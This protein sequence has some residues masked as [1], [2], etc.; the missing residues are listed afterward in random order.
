MMG[1]DATVG[2][3]NLYR[4]GQSNTSSVNPKNN[5]KHIANNDVLISNILYM[6]CMSVVRWLWWLWL[7]NVVAVVVV[8][9]E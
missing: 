4:H 1:N 3:I 9:V 2:N 6:F 5:M 8:V 7:S